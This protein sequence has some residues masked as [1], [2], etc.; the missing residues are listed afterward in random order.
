[1]NKKQGW[2][3]WKVIRGLHT[4]GLKY[5]YLMLHSEQTTLTGS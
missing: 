3:Q 5:K 1:M 2:I 4:E